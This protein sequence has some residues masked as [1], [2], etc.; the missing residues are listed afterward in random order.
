MNKLNEVYKLWLDLLANLQD[1]FL[2]IIR[3]YWGYGFFQ[4]G[5][6]KLNNME[7]TIGFFTKLG[8]VLPELNAY[9]AASTE[10]IGG[11]FLIFGFGARIFTIPLIFTMFIAYLTA[12]R[13]ELF[14]I[15][16]ETDKFLEA[17]PFL[18]LLASTIIL[19]FGAGRFSVD[20]LITKSK[21]KSK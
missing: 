15:F 3:L 17:S 12:H 1:I 16:S 19:L 13:E 4:A 2:L 11:L 14:A 9:L 5:L 20:Y 8:I 18:F 10:M 21:N 7:R 6:G